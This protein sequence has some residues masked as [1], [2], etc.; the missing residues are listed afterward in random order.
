MAA[1]LL[2]LGLILLAYLGRSA[3]GLGS[4]ETVALDDVSLFS[5]RLKLAGRPDRIIRQGDVLIPEEWKSAKR[6]T[7]GHELQLGV[8]CLLIEEKY[9]VRPPFGMVVLGNG[10]RVEVKN[11]DALRAEVLETAE[12]IRR[13]RARLEAEIPVRQPAEKCRRCGQRGNCRQAAG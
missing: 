7:R 3:R 2:G 13:H 1:A 11:T 8:Y 10:S 5:S 6:V 4:G 9:G 12:K